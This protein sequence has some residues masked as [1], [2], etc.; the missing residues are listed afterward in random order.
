M[1]LSQAPYH[2][3]YDKSKNYVKQLAVGGRYAQTREFT[4]LQSMFLTFLKGLGDSV[5]KDG[6]RVEGCDITKEGNLITVAKGRLYLEGLVR[7]TNGGEVTIKG[8]GEEFVGCKIVSSIVTAREDETLLD[9]DITS[10]SYLHEGCDRLKQEVIFVANDPLSAPLVKFK[11]GVIV[12]LV[13]DA[14]QADVMGEMLAR[15][16]FDESGNYVVTGMNLSDGKH[17]E[18]DNLLVTLGKGKAYIKGYE[19][20][21]PADTSFYVKKSK[22]TRQVTGEP[23]IFDTLNQS[24]RLFKFPVKQ[25]HRVLTTVETMETLN[26][27]AIGGTADTLSMINVTEIVEVKQN[28]TVFTPGVDFLLTENRID[29]SPGGR[30]PQTGTNYVVKYRYKKVLVENTDYKVA[31]TGSQTNINIIANN[32]VP[33]AEMLVDYEFYLAR[34]DT[35]CLDYEGKISVVEGEPDE[36]NLVNAPIITDKSILKMGTICVTANDTDIYVV[37]NTVKVSTMERIQATIDRVSTLERNLTLTD[38]D[39][40]VEAGEPAT[41]M[42]GIFTDGFLNMNK[43]DINYPNVAYTM[44]V[45]EGKLLLPHTESTSR[46]NATQGGTSK[47]MNMLNILSCPFTETL[48]ASQLACTQSYLI[49]PYAVFRPVMNVSL[50]PEIDNWV[51]ESKVTVEQVTTTTNHLHR[52]WAHANDAWA[53]E[54]RRKWE[55]LGFTGD[56]NSFNQVGGIVGDASNSWLGIYYQEHQ[57]GSSY[58]KILDEAIT[59]IRQTDVEVFSKTFPFN[60]DNIQCTFDGRPVDLTPKDSTTAGTTPGSVRADGNGVV[61]ATFTIPE[62]VPTGTK[63]VKLFSAN[64]EG[65]ANYTASGRKVVIQ[66]TIYKE[67]V[68]VHA[69]DPLAETFQLTEDRNIT[70]LDLYFAEK[71]GAKTCSVQI[72]NV[73]NGYPGNVVYGECV[74]SGSEILADA[75]GNTPTKCRFDNVIKCEKNTQYCF[76]VLTDSNTMKL[77]VAKL[78]ERDTVTGQYVTSQAYVEGVMFSSSNAITWS[79][80]Q[81]MD[82]KFALYGAQYEKNG[83]IN[84]AT[85]S[86]SQA[87][88]V[89]L[90]IES[91]TPIG[92]TCFYEVSLDGGK[93]EPYLP[94]IDRLLTMNASTADVRIKMTS[95]GIQSPLVNSSTS[96]IVSFK[97]NL[98]ACYVSRTI[99]VPEGY[100]TI[101][102]YINVL[103]Q[104][105][106]NYK[107]FYSTNPTADVWNEITNPEITQITNLEQENFYKHTLAQPAKTFRVKVTMDTNASYNRPYVKKLRCSMTTLAG[108]P[109]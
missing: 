59:Y 97:N 55:A 95:N 46:L 63:E 88:R 92:C 65:V 2:D 101:K 11:D 109:S 26:R 108:E 47:Y 7:E 37:S 52:W 30:E 41:D 66:E 99:Q 82:I 48:L 45:V 70:A 100:N 39:R 54:E 72:R 24:Y 106:T 20:N 21:K 104:A 98:Q 9:P 40:E 34:K 102:V 14:P 60:E 44:D 85:T 86:L 68:E 80:H 15:R 81:D 61:T 35:V 89:M 32:I 10:A 73:V 8:V 105:S 28:T 53:E 38:L 18:G 84:F 93:Y 69:V 74:L 13:Q 29:W 23:K 50:D 79:A 76:V 67:R 107:V 25:V 49:N 57:T 19:I 94:Y 90:A 33:K 31:T 71:D 58:D 96:A 5:F 27:G 78:G 4:E 83:E 64:F 22:T 77:H 51:E 17:A 3:K 91:V 43:I 42:R 62:G 75:V 6:N 36:I 56:P 87:D 103:T 16:T 12:S 1:D